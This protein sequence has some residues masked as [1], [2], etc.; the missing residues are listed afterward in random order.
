MRTA[1]RVEHGSSSTLGFRHQLRALRRRNRATGE[2][3]GSTCAAAA[4]RGL[5]VPAGALAPR[6]PSA[7]RA[8]PEKP[9][10][11]PSRR[12]DPRSGVS[13]TLP[14]RPQAAPAARAWRAHGPRPFHCRRGA[15]RPARLLPPPPVPPDPLPTRSDPIQGFVPL[16]PPQR[17]EGGSARSAPP[18][19][20]RRPHSP[21][22]LR[23]DWRLSLPLPRYLPAL[24]VSRARGLCAC[25]YLLRV[26]LCATASL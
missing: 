14:R 3:R 24:A 13:S 17:A 12:S 6:L 19:T 18:A 7:S 22:A 21:P 23:P 15:P 2:G 4:S 25:W 10:L 1:H 16:A 9:R 11:A 26:S 8:A 20:L 5:Q